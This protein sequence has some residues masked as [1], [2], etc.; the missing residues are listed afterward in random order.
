MN[1]ISYSS[2]EQLT[3]RIVASKISEV[4]NWILIEKCKSDIRKTV[5]CYFDNQDRRQ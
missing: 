4:L 2:N 5:Q 1:P 3:I